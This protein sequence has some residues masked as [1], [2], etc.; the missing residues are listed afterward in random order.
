MLG[1]TRKTIVE[2]LVEARRK[3]RKARTRIENLALGTIPSDSATVEP[4]RQNFLRRNV[5][6]VL[7]ASVATICGNILRKE[8]VRIWVHS[9][10]SAQFGRLMEHA[11]LDG[12]ADS[13]QVIR[14]KLNE[15]MAEKNWS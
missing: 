7:R 2:V 12:S 5:V 9:T 11:M 3:K 14:R 6:L 1:T 15:K 13:C 8:S 4:T 10:E